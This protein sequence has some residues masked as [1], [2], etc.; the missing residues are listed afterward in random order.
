MKVGVIVLLGE[1]N[2]DRR[3]RAA[4]AENTLAQILEIVRNKADFP[5]YIKKPYCTDYLAYFLI[6]ILCTVK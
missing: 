2:V 4:A 6:R 5:G 3:V 1:M